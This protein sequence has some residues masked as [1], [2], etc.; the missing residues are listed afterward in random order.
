MNKW[1]YKVGFY[2]LSMVFF[3]IIVILL[4]TNIPTYFGDDWEFIGLKVFLQKGVLIPLICLLFIIGSLLFCLW[5]YK[6]NKGS[7]LGP[8]TDTI[9]ENVSGDVMSFVAS[10]FFPLVS[11]NLSATWQHAVV[12]FMLFILIGAIYVQADIYYCNP[13]LM[14]L[15]FKVYKV[16][17]MSGR[18]KFNHTII[19]WDSLNDGDKIKYIPIDKR[20][21][22]A[23]KI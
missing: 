11:F 7:R 18:N 22:F 19:T 9:Y 17:G 10:Y 23:Y 8:V 6:W 1:W 21:S 15:G 16:S 5:L 2:L 3:L 20:T 4:G 12:L 13:T 14:I